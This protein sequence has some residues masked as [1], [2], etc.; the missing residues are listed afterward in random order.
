VTLRDRTVSALSW[1]FA[2]QIIG[3]GLRFGI[4]V[5]LARLLSPTEF[6][7]VGMV[8]VFT[9]FGAAVADLG[10]NAALVHRQ[11]VEPRHYS[12]VFWLNLAASIVMVAALWLGAPHIGRFYDAPDLVPITLLLSFVFPLRLL[13]VV[14]IAKLQRDLNF[15]K[16]AIVDSTVAALT[17]L[18]AIVLALAGWGVHALVARELLL[19]GLTAVAVWWG[20]EWVPRKLPDKRSAQEL[21]PFGLNLMGF[22]MFN[23][24]V[25][26]ADN[27]LIGRFVGSHGL[28]LYTRAYALMLMPVTQVGGALSRVMFPALSRIQTERARVKRIY[29]RAIGVV[30]LVSF[31]LMAGLVAVAGDFVLGLL[32]PRWSDVIPLLQV[33]APVGMMQSVGATVGWL[34]QSQGRTDWQFRWGIFA[35]AVT[36]IAFGIG[37]RWGVMGVAV[38]YAV[39]TLLLVYP[40]YAIPGRLIGLRFGEVFAAVRGPLLLA[41]AMALAVWGMALA[42][43][44]DWHPLLRLGVEV[45][46]GVAVYVGLL[47]AVRPA[48]Y[49]DVVELG[50]GHLRK[51]RGG[52]SDA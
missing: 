32:G 33:L 27:L 4:G 19:P 15:R 50:G 25:R 5:L 2:S 41:G 26:N 43:P 9:G 31:P 11:D 39:R 22:T 20:S 29:L 30:A 12:T 45:T 3:Q 46:A 47:L 37:I 14:P 6:G 10:L 8:L 17:G 28:G 23:Y 52:P 36:L 1:S 42:L 34:Y 49:E 40:S 21:L 18:L 51:I 35:G 7:L 24:W 13:S 44:P 38:A 48:A 16:L